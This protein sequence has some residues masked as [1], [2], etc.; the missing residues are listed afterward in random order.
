[1]VLDQLLRPL[2]IGLGLFRGRLGRVSLG[3]ALLRRGLGGGDLGAAQLDHGLEK[4]DVGPGRFHCGALLVQL[5]RQIA[6][7]NLHQQIPGLHRLIVFDV[8][9][10]D[11]AGE[12]WARWK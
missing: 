7:V 2:E 3:G 12:L 11:L 6:R 10:L 8:D 5:H 1:M 9:L 4:R